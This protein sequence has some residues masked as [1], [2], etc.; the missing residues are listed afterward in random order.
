MKCSLSTAVFAAGLT[1]ASQAMADPM[2]WQN[3]SLTYLYGKNFAVDSGEDG[4][5]ADIQQTI[6]FEHASGWTW[7]DM[8]LFVDNIWYNGVSGSDGHTYY[9]EF[10]PRLSLGKITGQEMSFGPIKDVL[11]AATYERGESTDGVPNQNYLLGPAVDL[12]VPGFDRLAINVYYRKPDGTTGT[13][14]G[15]V[16]G[17][18]LGR[19]IDT[20]GDRMTGTLLGGVA[21][22]LAGRAIEKGGNNCR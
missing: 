15:A 12:D 9:G 20:D 18:L 19:T 21:G 3:N 5:E 13:V 16:G 2:L 11:L 14:V 22:A 17:A 7:G 6:T 8:F 1:F 4:R 10:S